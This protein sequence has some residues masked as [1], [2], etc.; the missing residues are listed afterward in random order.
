MGLT[1][2]Q[3]LLCADYHAEDYDRGPLLVAL[4]H[5]SRHSYI[6]LE[7]WP[8]ILSGISRKK[9]LEMFKILTKF[10]LI[11]RGPLLVNNR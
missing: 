2:N 9:A 7:I 5:L 11:K 3:R 1:N 4:G 8:K 6:I 10:L